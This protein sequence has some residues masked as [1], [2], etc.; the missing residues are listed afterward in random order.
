MRKCSCLV[1]SDFRLRSELAPEPCA[2]ARRRRGA[3][4]ARDSAESDGRNS[5][6]GIP[7]LTKRNQGWNFFRR[8]VRFC[9][10]SYWV[11]LGQRR[12]LNLGHFSSGMHTGFWIELCQFLMCGMRFLSS[13]LHWCCLH[14]AGELDVFSGLFWVVFLLPRG[15][16]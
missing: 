7:V 14:I 1:C 9:R 3:R 5:A 16:Q 10:R 6:E 4:E 11:R 12:R 15:M 13:I 8:V 2:R